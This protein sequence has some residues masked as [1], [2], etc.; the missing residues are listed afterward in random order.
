MPGAP[1]S[2]IIVV[3]GKILCA[4]GARADSMSGW[5]QK[6]WRALGCAKTPRVVFSSSFSARDLHREPPGPPLSLSVR[7][8]I[9]GTKETKGGGV[10]GVRAEPAPARPV[11]PHSRTNHKQQTN[12]SQTSK[13]THTSSRALLNMLS[14]SPSPLAHLECFFFFFLLPLPTLGFPQRQWG[15]KLKTRASV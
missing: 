7:Q 2:H 9:R 6:Y 3:P 1:G 8:G 10:E 12:T 15:T 5:L 13:Q 14:P 4:H 11:Q